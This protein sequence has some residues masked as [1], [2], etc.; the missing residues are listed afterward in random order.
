MVLVQVVLPLRSSCSW[1]W[2]PR[3]PVVQYV[4][5]FLPADH[6][7][8]MTVPSRQ[9][10]SLYK[11]PVIPLSMLRPKSVWN[12]FFGL[13]LGAMNMKSTS[14]CLSV[15][16]MSECSYLDSCSPCTDTM[17]SGII[18]HPGAMNLIL[19]SDIFSPFKKMNNLWDSSRSMAICLMKKK[20]SLFLTHPKP[21]HLED[22]DWSHDSSRSTHY[23]WEVTHQPLYSTG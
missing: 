5:Q 23:W 14:T 4:L 18:S 19:C 11:V 17:G 13:V 9:R 21:T 2:R 1:W 3:I 15:W 12:S 10:M 22:N 7:L 16:M 20:K 8:L 6:L